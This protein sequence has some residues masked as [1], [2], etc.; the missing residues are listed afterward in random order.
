[1]KKTGYILSALILT[2]PML[3]FAQ[4][5]GLADGSAGNLGSLADGLTILINDYLVPLLM[6]L[7]FLAFIWGMFQFFIAGAS[8]P[9]KKEKGK[10][11][12]IYGV[13]GFVLIII[14][15][16]LV[17]FLAGATGLDN[18]TIAIPSAPTGSATP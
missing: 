6:A 8:D 1:M 15:W 7:A 18:G 3:T 16:G 4:T 5:T 12:M 9:E 10:A 11:V 13:L 14:L 2:M 17:N